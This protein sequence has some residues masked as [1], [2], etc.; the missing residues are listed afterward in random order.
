MHTLVDPTPATIAEVVD[1]IIQRR[2]AEGQL[3]DA[4]ITLRQLTVVREQFVRTL[5]GMYHGRIEYPTGTGNTLT[6]TS[7]SRVSA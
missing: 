2:L 4:P 7:S 3:N 6:V 5:A 1:S